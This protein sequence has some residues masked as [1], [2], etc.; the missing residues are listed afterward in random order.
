MT[1][2]A[3]LTI[4]TIREKG[5]VII[6]SLSVK[7]YLSL[8]AK[9]FLITQILDLCIIEEDIKKIDFSLKKFAYEYILTTHYTNVDFE[10]N[11]ILE[12]YD[13]LK[14][15]GVISVILN[16]IPESEKEFIDY[17]LRKEIEQVQLVDNSLASVVSKQLNKIVEKL[18]DQKGLMKLIKELPKQFNKVSPD[19]LKHLSKAMGFNKE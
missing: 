3:L 19:S 5:Y 10:D 4:K 2:Q 16:I 7:Q 13:E 18:P 8:S 11:N 6:D 14:E 9:K 17:V 1:E 15:N 12:L